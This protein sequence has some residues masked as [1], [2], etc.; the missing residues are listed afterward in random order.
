MPIAQARLNR[1]DSIVCNAICAFSLWLARHSPMRPTGKSAPF[2]YGNLKK[3]RSQPGADEL[4]LRPFIIDK[5][6]ASNGARTNPANRGLS[7]YCFPGANKMTFLYRCKGCRG[8]SNNC[9]DCQCLPGNSADTKGQQEQHKAC[10]LVDCRMHG[11]D[12]A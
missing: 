9:G 2:M 4:D 5:I 10:N 12:P 1:V 11:N 3:E 7:L 6:A 8:A